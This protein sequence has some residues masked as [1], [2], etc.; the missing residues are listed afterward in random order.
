MSGTG[1]ARVPLVLQTNGQECGAACL[2]MML[3]AHGIEATLADCRRRLS[4]DERGVSA[5]SIVAA[6][7]R[8]GVRARG[9]KAPGPDEVRCLSLPAI[10]HWSGDHYVVLESADAERVL[11]LDPSRGRRTLGWEEFSAHY[12][13]SALTFEVEDEPS[14]SAVEN[15]PDRPGLLARVRRLLALPAARRFLGPLAVGAVVVYGLA[16]SLPFLAGLTLELLLEGGPDAAPLEP[17]SL[18]VVLAG[19]AVRLEA[20]APVLTGLVVALLA[21]GFLRDRLLDL[22]ALRFT[23]LLTGTAAL[24]ALCLPPSLAGPMG[25][26]TRHLVLHGAR[27]VTRHALLLVVQGVWVVVALLL[28]ATKMPALAA[29]ALAAVAAHVVVVAGGAKTRIAELGREATSGGDPAV[30]AGHFL[31][32]TS[33]QRDRLGVRGLLVGALRAVS[34]SVLLWLAVGFA[35]P[36]G[37]ADTPGALLAAA[38]LALQAVWPAGTM[39]LAARRLAAVGAR[40]DAVDMALSATA[41]P[42]QDRSPER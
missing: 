22:V 40:I 5:A 30:R 37:L 13:G 9:F 29:A 35:L 42:S 20:L 11:L 10:A 33:N 27:A 17:S 8:F 34:V 21:V 19:T 2:A 23:S 28:V 24:D 6:A 16:A 3:G 1:P 38:S 15:L 32:S 31:L 39:A 7:R 18:G 12:A 14:N 25:A 26:S 36:S 41:E 4:A